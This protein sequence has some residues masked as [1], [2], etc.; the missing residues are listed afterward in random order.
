MRAQGWLIMAILGDQNH[1]PLTNPR[2]A[3]PNRQRLVAIASA[4]NRHGAVDK[5]I[6]NVAATWTRSIAGAQD[7]FPGIATINGCYWRWGGFAGV[8]VGKHVDGAADS[9]AQTFERNDAVDNALLEQVLGGLNAFGHGFA[10][11][12]LDDARAEEAE[13]CAGLC[14]GEVA[15]RPPR[16]HDTTGGGIAQ[17]HQEWQVRIL[18]ARHCGGNRDHERERRGALL[19]ASAARGW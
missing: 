4:G 16:R 10:G 5:G 6:D 14:E 19:H 1:R 12:E 13:K 2:Q 17:V 15:C 9:A 11:S 3:S 7:S 18:V 8:S